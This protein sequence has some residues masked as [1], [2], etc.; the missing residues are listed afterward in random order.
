MRKPIQ[1]QVTHIPESK[2]SP[3]LVIQT[4][5]CDDGTLWHKEIIS[6]KWELVEPI[7]DTAP[8]QALQPRNEDKAAYWL[9]CLM[10]IAE[11]LEI[12][13]DQPITSAPEVLAKL[14]ADQEQKVQIGDI[15]ESL[16][17]WSADPYGMPCGTRLFAAPPIPEK[18]KD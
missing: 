14:L 9:N 1:I 5:L 13:E 17:W 8:G 18:N 15:K 12:P 10:K 11:L 16:I 4:V 2:G 3:L 6:N 7:P